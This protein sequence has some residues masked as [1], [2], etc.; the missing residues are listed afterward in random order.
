MN[1]VTYYRY[2]TDNKAQ[3]DNSELRQKDAVERIVFGKGWAAVASFTDHAVSGTDDKPQLLEMKQQVMNGSLHVDVIA[4]DSLSRITRRSPMKMGQDLDWICEAG[5]LLSIADRNNGEPIKVSQIDDDLAMVVNGWQNNQYVKSLSR[6]V[7]NGMRVKFANGTMGWV[8]R[9][10]YGYDLKKSLSGPTTLVANP[11]LV[12]IE[13]VFRHVLNGGS[14]NGAVEILQRCSKFSGD[15]TKYPTSGSVKNVLRNSIYAGV[16]TFGVRGVGKHNTVGAHSRKWVSQNPLVQAQSYREY[17]AEGFES[18]ITIDEYNDVQKMLDANQNSFKRF[19]DR[20]RHLYSGLLRCSHCKAAMNAAP[21]KMGDVVF[22]RYVCP[23]S[24]SVNKNCRTG[25]A[26]HRKQIR[27][28]E[29]ENMVSRQF[30]IIL[31]DRGFH[32]RNLQMLVNKMIEQSRSPV[33]FID[34][35]VQIQKRR[36]TELTSLFMATGAEPLK[37]EIQKQAKKIEE[38]ANTKSLAADQDKL[39]TFA[40]EQFE[41]VGL[42][43]SQFMYFGHMYQFAKDLTQ[44]EDV[45]EREQSVQFYADRIAGYTREMI[46]NLADEVNETDGAFGRLIETYG[47]ES[48]TA[49]TQLKILR[50]MGLDHIKVG[51]E[52][53]LWRGQPRQVPTEL[54]FVF[55]VAS[56]N[57]T[58]MGVVMN[59]NQIQLVK[60][61]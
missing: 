38:I 24:A 25:D 55:T 27:V 52:L 60:L 21:H 18:C 10:P 26:P 14:I 29:L 11:D 3:L 17:A 15:N 9:A 1:V 59:R 50:Q 39:I 13:Q 8:G 42:S 2:S 7:T 53:G 5:I 31:M 23:N 4:I 16:R 36:L 54:S 46:S 61:R 37:D 43:P 45:E 20:Q 48:I 28:D 19:P 56:S 12:I 22:M 51:F 40:R 6:S 33:A 30:G 35:D 32:K 41:K 57:Y 58:D 34:A 49:E 44:I 47:G